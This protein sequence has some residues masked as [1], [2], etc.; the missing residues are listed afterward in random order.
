MFV[1][2]REPGCSPSHGM[3]VS[4]KG[5]HILEF[6]EEARSEV[7]WWS[8]N[9]AVALGNAL[10][11]IVDDIILVE[12]RRRYFRTV[13]LSRDPTPDGPSRPR[14]LLN[15]SAEEPELNGKLKAMLVIPSL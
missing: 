9:A 11:F 5:S 13:P 15:P 12:V 14:L 1:D 4:N 7:P 3:L 6:K 8:L 10:H 2:E